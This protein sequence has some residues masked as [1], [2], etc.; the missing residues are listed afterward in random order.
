MTAESRD[1][2]VSDS[3]GTMQRLT[4]KAHSVTPDLSL[5]DSERRTAYDAAMRPA[6]QPPYLEAGDLMTWHYGMSADVLLVVQDDERGLV[7]WLPSASEQLASLPVD[8]RDLR[9]RPLAERFTAARELR[10]RH[11][12]GPGVLRIAPTGRPWSI[13]Y[14]R[15]ED[16]SFAGL[17]VNLELPH[18]RPAD[19][20]PR[21][22]TRDLVLDLWVEGGE[23]WLKDADELEAVVVAGRFTPEQAQV[24]RDIGEQA[25]GEQI[26][27]RAWPLD[28]GW[29]EWQPPVGWEEPLALPESAFDAVSKWG[30][31]VR[32]PGITS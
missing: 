30:E 8:G 23:T 28:D 21:V 20:R 15:E 25:R 19:G 24:V 2:A 27:P 5:L 1:D 17:Y 14:F 18:E 3:G 4:G 6:G 32:R 16:G 29:E 9:D 11:W 22:H 26:E 13:C 10:V 31:S 12:Q 7:A